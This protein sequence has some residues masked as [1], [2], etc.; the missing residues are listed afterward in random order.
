M[1]KTHRRRREQ[2]TNGKITSVFSV[3]LDKQV[4]DIQPDPSPEVAC[5]NSHRLLFTSERLWRTRPQT[6]LNANA[7]RG[8]GCDQGM[9]AQLQFLFFFS[10]LD[11]YQ[12]TFR[13]VSS[14]H[15]ESR[16]AKIQILHFKVLS[17]CLNEWCTILISQTMQV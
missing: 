4:S 14:F 2:K 10:F 8:T 12:C 3:Y 1:K 17:C 15:M 6:T 9:P 13:S 16:S 11:L 5:R 7:D